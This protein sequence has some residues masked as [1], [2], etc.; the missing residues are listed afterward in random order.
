[1]SGHSDGLRGEGSPVTDLGLCEREPIHCPGEIQ[2]H[3]A[4][5]AAR[6]GDLRVT[7]ASAN[8]AAILGRPAEAVLGRPLEEAI[9]VDALRAVLDAMPANDAAPGRMH[10]LATAN[11]IVFGLRAHRSRNHICIDIEPVS[12]DADRGPPIILA[13]SVL[14]TFRH[15]TTRS[16]LCVQAV[17]G[18]RAITGYD[19]VMAYQFHEDGHGEVIAEA[20]EDSLEPFLGLHYPAGDVPPSARQLYL[21]QSVGSIAD[22]RYE[23]VPLRIDPASDDGA[24][25]DLTHSALRSASPIHREYMRNMNTAASLTV[26]LPRRQAPEAKNTDTRNRDAG[27]L[28]GMLVC[29]HATPRISGPAVR[30]VAGMI[31]QVV[32]LLLSSLGDAEVFAEK[33]MRDATLRAIVARFEGTAPLPAALAGGATEL[34]RLVY[35]SGALLRLDGALTYLGRTPPAAAAEH[36]LTVMTSAASGGPLAIDELGARYRELVGCT[37]EGAG[38]LLLPLTVGTDDAILWFRPELSRTVTWGGNPNEHAI[39]NSATGRLAPRASFAAWKEIVRGRSA[40]WSDADLELALALRSAFEAA[41]AQRTKAALAQ[42]RY[43]DSLTGLPNRSLLQERL[44]EVGTGSDRDAALVFLDLDRF[45]AVNDTMGHAA[46]DALLV[47]VARRLM[48]ASGPDQLAARLGGD[49]FVVLCRGLDVDGVVALGEAV[50]SALEAPFEIL[51]RTC[52]VSASI[53]IAVADRTAGLDL[54]RAADMAMYAAKQRGG[55]RGVMFEASLFDHAARQFEFDQDMRE[56]LRGDDQLALLYQPLFTVGPEIRTLSGFEALLRWRHPRRGWLSPYQFLPMAEKSGLILALGDWVLATA[57]HQVRALRRDG[58]A[59]MPWVTV[60]V[61]L[62]QLSQP[63][64]C[65]GL[66]E[67]LD[68]EGVPPPA[69]CLEV[70][71]EVLADTAARSILASLR[72]SGVRIASDDFGVGHASLILLRRLPVDFIKLERGFLEDIE[73]DP[74]GGNFA[75]A[76]VGLAHAAGKRVIF[77]GIETRAQY[78]LVVAAGADMAQGFFLAPPLS[79]HAAASFDIRPPPDALGPWMPSV[80]E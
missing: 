28:W 50:R 60:N 77:E 22:S 12:P 14:Q 4:V 52:R 11:G 10:P 62:G 57:L 54:V 19:R 26:G 25:L 16:E 34:L 63:G 3:G 67:L 13:Q 8:L 7:H 23:A 20:R 45:K 6:A 68:A 69:L 73:G 31:G 5:L 38:A 55:N 15:A 80:L 49:E 43:Y 37:D 36:V 27:D 33:F 47:E 39:L 17:R 40:P 42:L 2:P 51:G 44:T 46:G 21:R 79:P 72:D 29:H 24:P 56:A 76:V 9:G 64:F 71:A 74:R 48:A 75:G 53:G 1:V 30:A 65:S 41:A 78:E 59:T 18:L 58:S 35:A 32:S 70:T 61:S 66:V